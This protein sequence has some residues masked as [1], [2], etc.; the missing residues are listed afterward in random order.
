MA[1][2]Q[3]AFV[4]LPAEV[5]GTIGAY[6]PLDSL[7]SVRSTCKT[8]YASAGYCRE[9]VKELHRVDD[10][11]K[12][13]TQKCENWSPPGCGMMLAIGDYAP[14]RN[15]FLVA[16]WRSWAARKGLSALAAHWASDRKFMRLCCDSCATMKLLAAFPSEEVRSRKRDKQSVTWMDIRR[17][18]PDPKNKRAGAAET[19]TQG[20]S[21]V[22]QCGE[23]KIHLGYEGWVTLGPFELDRIIR[24]ATCHE[25]KWMATDD[26]RGTKWLLAGKECFECHI[27]R[28]EYQGFYAL[29]KHEET[30]YKRQVRR[31]MQRRNRLHM[32]LNR[33]KPISVAEAK[34]V[35]RSRAIRTS[36][37]RR[38]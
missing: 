2:T 3:N 16:N 29:V 4:A 26:P 1:T 28:P 25:D 37:H 22:R 38:R 18:N 10:E 17:W 8:L 23:C 11:T 33:D 31:V 30:L 13:A 36:S 32:L 21:F 6:L 27:K 20:V 35:I 19:A 34:R 5:H 9:T 15:R 12:V 7:M 24:C 14:T